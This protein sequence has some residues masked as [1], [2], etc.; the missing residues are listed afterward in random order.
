M[1]TSERLR[2][3]LREPLRLGLWLDFRPTAGPRRSGWRACQR[4]SIVGPEEVRDMAAEVAPCTIGPVQATTDVDEPRL[5]HR[6][7]RLIQHICETSEFIGPPAPTAELMEEENR[8]IAAIAD[9]GRFISESRLCDS[10]RA[11]RPAAE[12]YE[13]GEPAGPR[14]DSGRSPPGAPDLVGLASYQL[15]ATIGQL[16]S[17]AGLARKTQSA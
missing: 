5:E 13:I 7:E 9:A 1:D 10:Y 12:I 11:G 14:S 8:D 15:P 6:P 3:R 2:S 17:E 16:R 4:P